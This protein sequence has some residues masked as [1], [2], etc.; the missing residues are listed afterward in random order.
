MNTD[1]AI[2]QRAGE[3]ALLAGFALVGLFAIACAAATPTT[4]PPAAA[5]VTATS[6][7]AATAPAVAGPKRGGKLVIALSQSPATLNWLFGS[8]TAMNEVLEFIVEGMTR[9]LPDGTRVA[10]LAKEVPSIQNGGV[11]ADGK[12]ITYHLLDGLLWSDGTPVTCEDVKFTWQAVTTPGVGVIAPAGYSEVDSVQCPDPTTI[13]VKYKNFFAPYL[14]IFN[15]FIPKS[16]GELKDI[17][18]WAYNRKPVG[19]GPFKVDEWVADDHVTLS[20]NDKYREKDKPFLDQIVIRIVPSVDVAKQLVVSGE[21][22]IMWNNTE[23]DIPELQKTPGV[24]YNSALLVGGERMFLNLAE[25]KD[26]SD[27]TKPHPIL[28]DVRV[29][30][31]IEYGINKQRIIDKILFGLATPGTSELNTGPF[32]CPDIKPTPFDSDKAKAMLAD[33]GWV[34][35]PDGIRVAKGAK[36]AP[37]GARLRLKFSTTTGTPFRESGQ[38]LIIEDMKAIGVDMYIENG[39]S[40]L[41]IGNWA[42]GSPRARGN[43]DIVEYNSNAGVDVNN[44]MTDMLATKT[45]PSPSNTGGRNYSRFSD[46]KVDALLAQAAGDPDFAKRKDLY[47][48][49]ARIAKEQVPMIFLYHRSRINSYRDRVQ[50]FDTGNAFANIGWNAA[51]WWVK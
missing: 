26:G 14:T 8:Q 38:V 20:R 10:Q 44:Q 16:A 43:F 9:V 36:F 30:Q 22:D 51:N 23:A 50:G 41:V 39:P 34:P 49:A 13:I 46:P 7:P 11:S 4:A 48:Q 21:A 31:A 47:C 24:K 5:P 32:A 2:K 27:P 33:A 25:N 6:A 18:N 29:R 1:S 17:K 19:T 12:T 37:D 35:G 15:G 40:A 42:D 3:I 45:I 28:G